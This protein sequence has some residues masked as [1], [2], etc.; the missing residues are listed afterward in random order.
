MTVLIVR[1]SRIV[2]GVACLVLGV[3]GLFLPFL[4][5]IL[6]LVIGLGLLSTESDR[7]RRWLEWLKARMKRRTPTELG[8]K[9]D[10]SE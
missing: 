7:A 9:T 2:L 3:V 10:G 4:Q 5:G 8:E 1:I 6:F